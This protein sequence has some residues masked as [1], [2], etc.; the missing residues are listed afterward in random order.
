MRKDFDKA[1][2]YAKRDV[3][4][5]GY[6]RIV[7]AHFIYAKGIG[8]FRKSNFKKK[9]I[10]GEPIAEELKKWSYYRSPSGEMVKSDYIYNIRLWE[11][12]M[13]YRES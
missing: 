11:I 8:N 5:T 10:S 4:V 13:Y 7:V 1:V 2:W 6:K 3:D 9:I 12:E